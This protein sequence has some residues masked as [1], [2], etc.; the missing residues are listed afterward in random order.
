MSIILRLSSTQS[1]IRP[2]LMAEGRPKG[3]LGSAGPFGSEIK[4]EL[5]EPNGVNKYVIE[6]MNRGT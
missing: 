5:L 6:F 1:S 4:A 2:E 3:S